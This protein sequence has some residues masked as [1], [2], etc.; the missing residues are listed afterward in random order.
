MRDPDP[1]LQQLACQLCLL[2]GSETEKREAV[3]RMRRL[4]P[5]ADIPRRMDIEQC[6]ARNMSKEGE[7]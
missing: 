2:C 7:G 6:L 4:L 5:D 1:R 3:V